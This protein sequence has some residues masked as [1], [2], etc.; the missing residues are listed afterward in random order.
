MED[1]ARFIMTKSPEG[2][3]DAR[4]AG[5]YILVVED[6]DDD[7]EVLAHLLERAG[8]V[9]RAADS[10]SHARRE[11]AEFPPDLVLMD[12]YLPAGETGA[13]LCREFRRSERGHETPVIFVTGGKM[14]S[15]EV[16]HSGGS[17][18]ILKPVQPVELLARIEMHLAHRAAL[19]VMSRKREEFSSHLRLAD[20]PESTD[21]ERLLAEARLAREEALEAREEARKANAAKARFLARMSHEMRTPLN[22][23]VGMAELLHDAG[24]EGEYRDYLFLLESAADELVQMVS[25][26]LEYAEAEDGIAVANVEKFSLREVVSGVIA[27]LETLIRRHQVVVNSTMDARVAQFG[28]G[29]PRLVHRVLEHFLGFAVRRSAQGAVDVAVSLRKTDAGN[30]FLRVTVTDS[31]APVAA[32][33]VEHLFTEFWNLQRDG[34][35]HA[36]QRGVGLPLARRLAE[37]MDGAVGAESVSGGGIQLWLDLPLE[38]AAGGDSESDTGAVA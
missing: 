10:A 33:E 28:N 12:F 19:R 15:Q 26:L 2:S 13:A 20:A 5:A 4:F 11:L 22:G 34:W 30:Q 21:M 35:N 37:N 17:D 1:T 8:Y 38:R 32:E 23:V 24:L 9:V 6:D 29:D 16:F 3:Q 18:Y 25:T 14:E 36:E 7:R 31:G 27:G